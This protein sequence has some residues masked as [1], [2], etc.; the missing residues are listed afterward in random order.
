MNER[1][2]IPTGRM[3]APQAPTPAKYSPPGL[4]LDL[5][6]GKRPQTSLWE[7]NLSLVIRSLALGLR[8]RSVPSNVT[9]ASFLLPSG[10]PVL[11][12]SPWRLEPPLSPSCSCQEGG[13]PYLLGLTWAHKACC[14]PGDMRHKNIEVPA[15]VRRAHVLGAWR[16]DGLRL[17]AG[18]RRVGGCVGRDCISAEPGIYGVE[19]GI[20]AGGAALARVCG[21]GGSFLCPR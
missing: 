9:Q 20:G 3:S 6:Q 17:R 13:R 12:R 18:W 2:K 10:G 16:A 5:I 7:G 8:G 1:Q 21:Q 14:S 19:N 15:D 11:P 4:Q